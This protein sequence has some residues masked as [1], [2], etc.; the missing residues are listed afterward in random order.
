M[1]GSVGVAC[2]VPI[3]V[4]HLPIDG[5][6]TL[7]QETTPFSI[8]DGLSALDD[9]CSFWWRYLRLFGSLIHGYG[10]NLGFGGLETGGDLE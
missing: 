2:P 5:R 1:N 3:L 6:P 4:L 8:G 7:T 9:L 10:F